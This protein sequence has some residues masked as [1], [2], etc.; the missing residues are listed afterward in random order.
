MTPA[1]WLKPTSFSREA[2]TLIE[3]LLVSC[4]GPEVALSGANWI[5]RMTRRQVSLKSLNEKGKRAK[6]RN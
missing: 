2:V 6:D 1:M 4:E 5:L 3:F